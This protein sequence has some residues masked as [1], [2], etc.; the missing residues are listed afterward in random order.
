L[1]ALASEEESAMTNISRPESPK[2]APKD[3]A[4]KQRLD[5]ELE[6]ALE[7]TFPASDPVAISE[8]AAPEPTGKPKPKKR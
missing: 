7:D 6:E 3:G 1:I 2:P 4:E 8:P 5:R